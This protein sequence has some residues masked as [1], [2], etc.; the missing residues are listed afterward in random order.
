MQQVLITG[1]T[2]LI[3][4]ELVHQLL[5]RE[6]YRVW[7]LTRSP[8]RHEARFPP[9]ANLIAHLDE[10]PP[11]D[12]LKAVINLAGAPIA[13]K[14][15]SNAVKK[16]LR[17]SRWAITQQLVE[18]IIAARHAPS[19]FISGSAIGF[20]GAQGETRL[21]EQSLPETDNFAHHLCAQWEDI[22]WAANEASRTAIIRTGVVLSPQGGMLKK[23]LPVYR[24]G[25]G[26]PLGDG[27][28][29]LS[30]IHIDDMVNALLFILDN[31]HA[32]GTFNMTS[33]H[34]VT[35][36]EFSATLARVLQKP[37]WLRVPSLALK[38]GLG[39]MSEMLLQ[40]QRVI[41]SH[42]ESLAFSFRYSQLPQAL[43]HLLDPPDGA[44]R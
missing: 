38:L 15:W 33:P 40:G 20:Y 44:A 3:G 29:Y 22:A 31:D 39:E 18:R 37:H 35:N 19:T 5:H 11:F 21:D 12:E 8:Q 32:K 23:L 6:D 10:A 2:G 30:W 17:E 1:G 14:R 9:H 26:A 41:P 16:E 7:I 4:S 42:L 28:Q 36:K 43:E 13:D 27:R 34:P 25:L 24:M